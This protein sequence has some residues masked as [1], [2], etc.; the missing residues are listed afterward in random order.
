M[1]KLASVLIAG[2]VGMG[3]WAV[4]TVKDLPEYFVAGRPYTI[5]F[6]VRQHGRTLL[7][8]LRPRLVLS[9]S[10]RRLGGLLGGKDET[11]IPAVARS[12]E[13][14]Y[15]VTFTAPAS[16][17]VFLTIKSGFGNSE[18][19]LYPQ[20]VVAAGASRPAMAAAD[21]GQVLFVAK[22][23]NVCHGN[24]DLTDRPDNQV[25]T[26]GPELGGRRL[27]RQYVLQVLK[28]PLSQNMPNVGLSDA[29]ALAIAAFL[30][31]GTAAG[32]ASRF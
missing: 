28:T 22:G 3:G 32:D 31:S 27:A 26:V 2:L 23:C 18:L 8:D 25:L 6:Q 24:S 5:E 14:T 21:R 10:E 13:G 15:A 4:V 16:E 29:D 20:P 11:T 1:L 19:R 9:S 30:T 17:Q 12:A 7:N